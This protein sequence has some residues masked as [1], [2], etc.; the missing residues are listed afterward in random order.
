LTQ[1]RFIFIFKTFKER[2]LVDFSDYLV[3]KVAEIKDLHRPVIEE[4]DFRGSMFSWLIRFSD[5]KLE[6][7]DELSTFSFVKMHLHFNV[8]DESF[9][10]TTLDMGD[11]S[12]ALGAQFS[13]RGEDYEDEIERELRRIIN[14]TLR[15]VK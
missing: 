11:V 9:V 4:F 14:R 2:I 8:A 7:S 10:V 3:R 12:G 5:V 6:I 13:R 1:K 15:G